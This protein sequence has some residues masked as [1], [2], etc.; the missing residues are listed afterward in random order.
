MGENKVPKKPKKK[1]HSKYK[2]NCLHCKE[3]F[4]DYDTDTEYCSDFC[5]KTAK[6]IIDKDGNLTKEYE[7]QVNRQPDG[8]FGP[9]NMAGAA[10]NYTHNIWRAKMHQKFRD[11]ATEEEFAEV[12]QAIFKKAKKGDVHAI[13]E[14]LERCLGKEGAKIDITSNDEKIQFTFD[15]NALNDLNKD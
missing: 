9:G 5:R 10:Q 7:E 12:T 15:I 4:K 14:V 13:K 2:H 6:G 8:T 3:D 1:E 11:C